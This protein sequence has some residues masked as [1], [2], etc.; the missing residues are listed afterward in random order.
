M[1]DRY[2]IET[3]GVDGYLLE[4]GTGVLLI[5][6][7]PTPTRIRAVYGN[8]TKP[9]TT[10]NQDVYVSDLVGN[11]RILFFWWSNQTATGYAAGQSGGFGVA[12]KRN[13]GTLQRAY[14][15]WAGDDNV[16]TSNVG[17]G[18][19][20]TA[21]IKIFTDGT[22]TVGDV[23][24]IVD[25][26]VTNVHGFRIN[27]STSSASAKIIHYLA[28]EGSDLA[29]VFLGSFT[30]PAS[31]QSKAYSGVGFQPSFGLFFSG[32]LLSLTDNA[33]MINGIGA[34]VS[35]ARQGSCAW[36]EVD[37]ATVAA[38]TKNR[39][40][41]ANCWTSLDNSL[42][43]ALDQ[44]AD[45]TSF[46]ADGF[47]LN[48][49]T[50]GVASPIFLALLTTGMLVDVQVI[51]TPS[52]TGTVDYQTPGKPVGVL[53]FGA[54]QGTTS[55]VVNPEAHSMI[56]G[57]DAT[58]EGSVWTAGDDTATTDANS[59]TVTDKILQ[60]SV[61]AAPAS[62]NLEADLSALTPQGFQLN[63]TVAAIRWIIAVSFCSWAQSD[64]D[65]VMIPQAMHRPLAVRKF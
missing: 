49:T 30:G 11:L 17:K 56:G 6:P 27:W 31:A 28:I 3:S 21:C 59:R 29:N 34:A 45:L 7:V 26:G 14:A 19:N 51:N 47:T 8:F 60:A 39:T 33:G 9:T 23:A 22:P 50:V 57:G 52:G 35:P 42:P 10:G 32:P 65:A 2:L 38:R 16:G 1:A 54:P 62:P 46:D 5:D 61:A 40:D 20:T 64:L 58:G 37:G 12:V 18:M 25:I 24:D 41:N 15:A 63:Y 55:N 53:I 13:D 4:D 36:A 43:P 44:R 48:H